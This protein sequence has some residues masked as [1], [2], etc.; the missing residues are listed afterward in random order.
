[1]YLLRRR[2]RLPV[3][4]LMMACNMGWTL[5][6][7][8]DVILS[9]NGDT[10]TRVI[11]L[12][13]LNAAASLQVGM[14]VTGSGIPAGAY[15]T[16]IL[17]GN[18]ILI[19]LPITSNFA[20]GSL[21]FGSVG[22]VKGGT[23]NLTKTGA[24]R[25]V[26]SGNNI[27]NGVVTLTEGT[28]QIGGINYGA[29]TWLNDIIENNTAFVFDA[30]KTTSLDFASNVVSF[31]PFER[32]G[33]IAGGSNAATINLSGENTNTALVVGGNNA[34]TVFTGN[35][36]GEAKSI[37]VKEG[38]GSLTWNSNSTDSMI[39]TIRVEG[40]TLV[41]GGSAGLNDSVSLS[42]SN[43][44]DARLIL[45]ATTAETM[46]YLVGGG[47]GAV[48]SFANGVLG[49]LSGNYL[50]STG[51][52]V[53]L[54]QDQIL[55]LDSS[56]TNA[57]YKYGGS[58]T[59]TGGIT[60]RGANVQE[61][62][63][64][65]TY[66]GATTIQASDLNNS[67]N[68]LRLGAYGTS[69]GVGSLDN[70]GFGSLPSTTRLQ[71]FAGNDGTA[72][73]VA[74]D[75]NGA[76]QTVSTLVSTFTVGDRKVFLRSGTLNINTLGANNSSSFN[77]TF[78]G[79]GTI[80]VLATVGTSGWN[81]TGD[82][83]KT[84]TGSVN[85]QGG[86]L[87][88][89]RS[90]GALG[91]L[92]HVSVNAP[93][94]LDILES[95]AI[96]SL[97]GSGTVSIGSARSLT[98]TSAPSGGTVG[99]AWSGS[100]TGF[101][102]LILATG[103]SLRLTSQ[104]QY[105]GGT[106]L[107]SGSALFLDYG[108][109]SSQLIPSGLTLNGGRIYMS[110]ST[111]QTVSSATLA[112]GATGIYTQF[113]L[114]AVSEALLNIT[115]INRQVGGVL[116]VRGSS[117]STAT[118]AATGGILGG[119][120]TYHTTDGTG[121]PLV[122]WA[123]P[124]GANNA[125]TGFSDFSS[126]FGAG[127]HTSVTSVNAAVT[128]TTPVSGSLGSLTF[129]TAAATTLYIGGVD[130]DKRTEIE[131][132]G[133]LVT[134]TV[135]S[136]NVRITGKVDGV[137]LSGGAGS[138]L[139]YSVK[140]ELIVHQHNT[141]GT[142]T[143]DA[144][145]VDMTSD[146]AGTRLT[147][148]GQGT[149]ILTQLNSY[150]GQ[151]SIFGGVLELASNG[152]NHGSLGN[153]TQP[154]QNY[155]YLVFNRSELAAASYSVANDIIG[156][157]ILRKTNAGTVVL[158][159][160]DSS[161]TGAT[162]VLQG[163][164][165]IANTSNGLGSTDGLTSVSPLSTLELRTVF[166]PETVVLNGGILASSVGASGLTGSLIVTANS[167]L[168]PTSSSDLTLSG[169]VRV[170]PE[171]I[172]SI[173]GTSGKV[174]LTNGSNQIGNM[175]VGA[176]MALQIGDNTAGSV[177]RGVITTGANSDVITNTNNGHLV[178]GSKI[179]GSGEFY[180]VRNTVY[181]TADN[182][183]TGNTTIGGNGTVGL[184]N[185][186]AELRVGTDTYTGNLGTGTITIQSSTNSNSALRYHLLR[187]R[188]VS[189]NIFI[190]PSTNGSTA[191]NATLLRQGIGSI[192]LAGT[193][194]AG[195]HD[196]SP[197][198][199]RAIIQTE[200]GGK[201][202]I[203]G[204]INNGA[205]NA[206]NIINNG[207]IV[208]GGSNNQTLWGILSSGGVNIF[209]D[210]GTITLKG[211]NVFTGNSYI[212]TGTLVVDNDQGLGIQDDADFYLAN[213]AKMQFNYSETVGV[214]VSQKG[215][216]VQ[217][218]NGSVLTIDDNVTIGNFGR[219]TGDG[220][221]RLASNT[222]TSWYGLFGEN[223]L[224][225]DVTIGGA[226]QLTTVRVNSLTMSGQISSLGTGSVVN[227]GVTG[228]TAETRFE[229]I[230]PGETTDRAINLNSGSG[231]IR[232]AGNGKGAL[233][234]DGPVTVTSAGNKTLYLHGQTIGNTI[235]GIIDESTSVLSL[236][237][238]SA[239]GNNDMYGAGRWILTNQDN[240]FSGNVT[241][242]VGVLELAGSLGN[243]TGT[244]SVFGDLTAA[245][246]VD[247]GTNNFD[248][249]RFDVFSGGDNLG[250]GSGLTSTGTIVF[251]DQ[252]VGI[253]TFGSNIKFT[254]SFSSTTNPGGGELV[255]NGN[256]V[257][258]FNGTFTAGDSGNRNW[259]L[260]GTNT[261]TNTINGVISDT[262]TTGS[263]TVGVLKEGSGTWR[264]AGANTYEGTT[265]VAR[266]T[267]ELTGGLAIFDN[268]LI[269]L[270]NAGSDS[271]ADGA[272]L[273]VLQSET[274]GGL[275]G[276]IGSIVDI[277]AGQ[278]L[279]VRSATQT[280]NGIISGLGNLVRTNNDGTFREMTLTNKNTYSGTTTITTNG[281]NFTNNR[282]NLFFL[283][284]GGQAS[285]IGSSSNAA[286]NL[287]LNTGTGGGG[288]RWIGASNQTTDRLFTLGSGSGAGAIWAD[289]Q[290]F[291]DDPAT[292]QFTNT[293]AIEFL[294]S[295]TSQTLT[296]RG[297]NISD[298]IFA[299]LLTNNGS[300]VTS[301]TK[302]DAGMWVLT[303]SNTYSGTTTISG[304]TLAI[305]NGNALGSGSV[306]IAGGAGTGLQ[307]R[308]GITFNNNI[309]N[310][311]TDGGFSVASGDNVLSGTLTLAGT[312]A[313][314]RLGV[315]EGASLNITSA[316]GGA[317]GSA[318]LIKFD[319]GTL[320]LSGNNTYSG[321][322]SISGGTVV[323]NYDT[324]AGGTNSSKLA[325]SQALELG[326][327]NTTGIVTGLGSDGD[328]NGQSYQAGYA[329]GTLILSGGSH[330]EQVG[331]T[332]INNGANAVIR[333]GGTA[334]LQMG[335]ITRATAN[336]VADYGTVD[337]SE[338]GIATTT[339]ANT[340]GSILGNYATISQTDWA[341]VVN[342]TINALTS[343][344]ADSFITNANTD[345]T[346]AS[347][348]APSNGLTN[349]IRFNT[350]NGGATTLT[351]AGILGLQT[352]GILVTKNVT[353]DI[354][355][356]GNSGIL[357]RS[358]TTAN[359]DTVI[360]HFGSG[361]L[362]INVVLA[363]NSG[364]QALTKT[365]TGTV[366][367]NAA[368]TYTGRVN[369]QQGVLQIGNGT[370]TAPVA[371]LG[372]GSNPISMS[373]GATLRLSVA[374][375]NL[376]FT[377]GT[378]NGGG[379]LHLD[380]TNKSI[381]TLASDNG[382]WVGDILIQGGTLRIRANNNAL[383]NIRGI[384][385]IDDGGTLNLHGT[386]QNFPERITINQGGLITVTQNG[387]T[388]SNA[389][390]SG[391]LTLANTNSAGASF[392]VAGSQALT[393]TGMIRSVNG[394]TKLG[395]GILTISAN[396]MQEILAGAAV[397][398]TTPN[399]NPA[400]LGQVIINA[401]EVRLGNARALGA[402]GLGNE[403]IVKSGAS[404]DL[405]GQSLNY[406][407]DPTASR[408]II[409]VAG[410]GFNGLGA[411]KSSNGIGRVSSVVFDD[412]ATLSGGGFTATNSSSRLVI[413]GYDINPNNSSVTA[414]S[415][416]D[417][418]Y[419][420][421][422]AVIDGKNKN[423]TILGSATG[424][425]VNGTGVTLIDP[426]F[427]S[428]LNSITVSEG[429]LRIEKDANRTGATFQGLSSSNVTNGITIA[430]GGPTLADH[431]NSSLG[432]GPN[433]GA[434]LNFYRNWNTVHSVKITMDGDLAKANGGAN[435]IDL[436]TDSSIPNPRT[437]L[438][439]PIILKGDADRNFFHIDASAIQQTLGEQGNQ[440]GTIQSK[441]IISSQITGSGGFTKTGLRELRL[442]NNNT[443]T[444]AV[445]VLRSATAAVPWQDNLVSI[446]GV[447]YQ[448][449]GDGE[450]WAE[451]GMTL[452]GTNGRLSGTSSI[453]LQRRGLITLDNTNRLDA[454]NLV[455]GGN[456]NDRINNAADILF[457][458]G[459]LKIIGGTVDNSES[460]A[461]SG[462][463]KLRVQSG[464]NTLDLMPTD[465]ANTAMTLTI[466]EIVRSPGSILQIN[467]LDSTS[468]FDAEGGAES[469]RVILN[470]IGSLTQVGGSI[471]PGS[472]N[473][474]VV[475]GLL[476]GI[477]PHEYLSDIR[478]LSYNNAGVSDMLNQGRNQQYI[479]SSHFMT[480][481]AATK[482]LRPLDDSEYY[483]PTDG[484]I[485]SLNGSAG[486]NVNL[487]DAYTIVRE[488]VA[489][490][491]LRFGPL[492]DN[493]GKSGSINSTTALTSLVDAHNIQ[494]YVDG[495]LTINSGMI[496]SAYF[497]TGNSNS[498]ATYIMGGTLNFGNR[499]AIINNQNATIRGTDGALITG[500]FEI[501]SSIAG[502]GGLLKTGMA[503]VVL[504]GFNTYSGVT[505]V[506]N[507]T[508]FIRNGR[509]GLGVSGEGNGV[510]IEGNGSLNSGNGIQVGSANAYEN[511]LVKALQGDQQ[512]MRVDNDLTNWF[513]NVIIDNVDAAGQT[514]FTPR[515]R[516]DNNASSI[517]NGNI[518]GG[519]T[520]I[521]D[522]VVSIDSRVVQFDSSTGN[523][524]FILRGQIGDKGD[525]NGKAIPI[526]DPI[527]TLPNLA[528]VRTNENEV[529]RVNFNG[530][531]GETNFMLEQQ[532][533]AAGRLTLIQGNM[534]VTYNP[535]DPNRDGTGFWTD[536]AI[537]KI[538]GASSA[539]SFALNGNTARQGFAFGTT[540]N[541]TSSIFLSKADQVFNMATF[542]SA[543]TGIKT[544]GG[545]NDSGTVY[546]GNSTGTG[547][548][549]VAN[550]A[551]RLYSMAG[552]TTVFDYRIVGNAGTAPNSTGIIKTGRGTVILQ[553][554]TLNAAGN[555]SFEVSGGTLILDHDGMN[556]ARVGGDNAIFGGGVIRALSN[557]AAN[558]T[559]SYAVTNNTNRVLQLKAGTTEV[560]AEGRGSRTLTLNIGNA[561]TNSNRANLTREVGASVNFVEAING[562]GTGI[563]NLN[564]N[565]FSNSILK[566]RLISWATYSNESRTALDFAMS[567]GTAS[568]RVKA[569]N[570]AGGEYLSNVASWADGMDVSEL[571]GSA[572]SG[573]L[574]GS[575]V[576]NTLRFDANAN[577]TVTI[578]SGQTLSLAGDGIA[579]AVLVS[580]NTA[581]TNKTITG[582]SIKAFSASYTGGTT[583]NSNV[584]TSVSSTSNL[585]VGMPISGSGIPSGAYIT[586]ING[587]SITISANAT[588]T[589]AGVAL[590]TQTPDLILHQYGQGTL[591][592]ASTITGSSSLTIAGPATTS[593]EQFG[594]TGVVKLTGNNTYTG[595]T[596]VTGSVLEISDTAALGI[597]PASVTNGHLTLNGGT[598]RWTG[599]VASLGN[600]GI[601]LQG[602]GGVIDVVNETGNLIVGTGISGTQASVTSNQIFR[603]D[604]V[605]MGAGSLTFLGNNASFQ[606][607]MDV[608]EGSLIVMADN[609][610]ANAGS[611]TLLGTSRTLA[612][613][614]ILR[615]G[616]NFQAFL[617]N[618]NNG[619]DWNIEEFFTF[620][621]SNTF[622]YG[623]LLDINANLAVDSLTDQLN[624]GSRRPL[625]L[626]GVLNLQGT[627][628]F[629]VTSNG[630]LRL[631][632]SSGY[633]TG[634]GDIVKDGQGQLHFRAN[635]PDWKGNLVIKQGAV[636]AGNQADVLGTGYVSGST[637]T[638]GD[639][640]RQGFAEL[641]VQNVDGFHAST[642]DI[643][644]NINV[645][646]NPTQTKRLG[647]D[648]MTN[649]TLV[650]Y[651]GNV[652]LNDNL[653]LLIRDTGIS[654]GGEQ[655][656]V[657]FNGSFIDGAITSGNLLVQT[658]DPDTSLNNQTSGRGFGYAVLNGDNSG[659]TGDITISNNA[660]Y[661]QDTTAI[662]RLGNSKALTAANDVIMNYNSILQAGGQTVTIGSLTTQGGVGNFYGD[663]GTMSASTNSSTEIIENAS[664]SK[665]NL[666]I[667]QST[668]V[669][670]EASWDAFFR[671]GTIN[672]QFF[673]PGANVQQVSASLSLT[674]AGS[675]WATLTLDNDYTGT[676]TVKAGVLQV[677]RNGV[678]DTGTIAYQNS[679][680]T[681]MTSVLS[682]GTIAGSG[683]VQGRLSV[684]SGGTLKTGDS[685]GAAIGTLTVTGDALFASGSNALLQLHSASY[686]N[687]GAL[688][689]TDPNYQYWRD[690]VTTDSFSTA[691]GDLV[692]NAQH[693]LLVATGTIAFGTGAKITL[694]N[695]GYTPKA[696]DVFQL[697]QGAGYV[698]NLNVG[699]SLRTGGETTIPNLDLIL[700]A[701]GGNLLWDV[702]LFNSHGIVMVV[703]T[704]TTLDTSAQLPPVITEQPSSNQSQT[705]KLDPGTLV[706]VSALAT[707]DPAA[708]ALRYQWLHNGIPES[709]A[710]SR[711][712]TYT[713]PANFN[714][715][716][717]YTVAVTNNYGTVLSSG[718]V[719]VLVEDLP[720]ITVDP[721]SVT[722]DPAS[723]HT[724]SIAVG[725]QDPFEY[726]WLKDGD[727]IEGATNATLSLT[728]IVEADQGYYSVIVTNVAGSATSAEAFLNVRDP[729]TNVA[730]AMSPE[731]S[732][733][734]QNIQFTSTH[735]G[736]GPFTYQWTKNGT[737]IPSA[738][739]SSYTI[740]SATAGAAGDYRL[741]V[742]TSV[743]SLPSSPLTL[744]LKDPVPVIAAAPVSQT[745]LSGTPLDLKVEATGR[746]VLRYSWKKNGAVL[747]TSLTADISTSSA[748]LED[749]GTYTVE[750]SN[751]A[752]KIDTT[753]TPVEIVVVDSANRYLPVGLGGTAVFTARVG[754]G[755][756]TPLSYEWLRVRTREIIVDGGE[757]GPE[758]DE[759]VIEEFYEELPTNDSRYVG[760]NSAV[761]KLN[762]VTEDEDGLYRCKITGPDQTAVYGS[763]LD[764]SIYTEAPEFAGT[765]TFDD[766][767]I[768]RAY[769][770]E[771]PVNREERFKSPDKITA[772]GLPPGLK[773]DPISGIISGIPTATKAGGYTVKVTLANKKG[774]VTVAGV[775][776]VLDLNDTIPGAWVGLVDR[777]PELGGDLGGRVDLIVTTKATYSGKLTLG[778]FSYSFKGPL[779]V[780][781]DSPSGTVY[782]KRSGKP[783][784]DPLRLDFVLDPVNNTI[785][786]GQI[787]D[788]VSTVDFTGWRQVFSKT[789]PANS[790]TGYYTT[791][792]AL[793]DD[794][795]LINTAGNEEVPQGAG[796]ATFAVATDG[797]LKIAGRMPDGEA[798]TN[799]TFV[800]PNG[801]LAMFQPMYK[802]IKPGGSIL[803]VFNIDDKGDTD[804]L[805]S[806][807]S[808]SGEISWIR[809]ASIKST[810]RLFKAGFGI[811]G[812][813]VTEPLGVVAIGGRYDAPASGK[814]VLGMNE[815]AV[816]VNNA[817]IDFYNGG[818]LNYTYVV[819]TQTLTSMNPD[820]DLAV[821]K[822]SKVTVLKETPNATKTSVKAV[823]KTG[824]L[825]GAFTTTDFNPLFPQKPDVIKR[826][827]KFQGV[828]IREET[829]G[830]TQL[831]GV[832][833][834]LLPQL[835][836]AAGS[837]KPATTDKTSPIYSGRFVF[838]EL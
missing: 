111:A 679:V 293:G 212:R 274:I 98:L 447:D 506:S 431:T 451:W 262:L 287:I 238:N 6:S 667:A 292:L 252:E 597:N 227:L 810:D 198:T 720:A 769:S 712:A 605:K 693:D 754:A 675:G 109:I 694:E 469:V 677:G 127:V 836:R 436:G 535:N 493:D 829:D 768:G 530:G 210:G 207:T 483:S 81:I 542:N 583:N 192:T 456:N 286:S 69:A 527:S 8:G 507:G 614:T 91:D 333:N 233:I 256:K 340:T 719:T 86:K 752:G 624:L 73:N 162:Q 240:N 188:V 575:K 784:P 135:G 94:E 815:P 289:G 791:A 377:S 347:V 747:A 658:D 4:I 343:Y 5:Q 371:R 464:T 215:S 128:A 357:R 125:I 196:L 372:A 600:R 275:T 259:I 683:I 742:T 657:N 328:V 269:S 213:G 28:L 288:L 107:N 114:P 577:S 17:S 151:T 544:I 383:G 349:T 750:V 477:M 384:T 516:T 608:R 180:Q 523:N 148:V 410:A 801:E 362:N 519:S 655:S 271:V 393:L 299:P 160:A 812:S 363:N 672:S 716:G 818:D 32:I 280:Y 46:N 674:K 158:R 156:S 300:G 564:F 826:G 307:F 659:W 697:F 88:L 811:A 437:Y 216:V 645:V 730:I 785:T 422:E 389:T 297:S 557:S 48:T 653:I 150:T 549:T 462:G 663:A 7:R 650:A 351:L 439:G 460:L 411:L 517:I 30:T 734:G 303:N 737:N 599:G 138:A 449:F 60:K 825:S 49:A 526:A 490:N 482:V 465:G 118:A 612:D 197:T 702:S 478:Q 805:N 354:T 89:N 452:S 353:D 350:N 559:V 189:N 65:N 309:T 479:A 302:A 360:H 738:N 783:T 425:D 809:P 673:A 229:Y 601:D 224:S 795:P 190:N 604:L 245:R 455:A 381:F 450:A 623:S 146:P 20:S 382:N 285:G 566:N 334:V 573:T 481:D 807:N 587:N 552:G 255:N 243:G 453:N 695:D 480:Y 424:N 727:P 595:A 104:Q 670:Y 802:A 589:N 685:A 498:L 67:N 744:V 93:G 780:D 548:L 820:I 591:T 778:T 515:I 413:A 529:L 55:T 671:D 722:V 536:T 551:L 513:S 756:K 684:L 364:V 419:Q 172:L 444:G 824:L 561:N 454:T 326:F 627:A 314:L 92:V 458:H 130:G 492:S 155:G 291:G 202:T 137:A 567:D 518:Y 52:E 22:E 765:L 606:G 457:N 318:R 484:L 699:P 732:F 352:G 664:A 793:P 565:N 508:L 803:G 161:Y 26:L 497:S 53:S 766:A 230:G 416:L 2:L 34:S 177:G 124:N 467:D 787:T 524:V 203:S 327:Y 341:T 717:T 99:N 628:T 522:D 174:I 619:G 200:G 64:D 236:N 446:N 308:G 68:I 21:T 246:V 90:G 361:L 714:T 179:T 100:I 373:D 23:G 139:G 50:N 525:A 700:F 538:P 814:V 85:V 813:P 399:A 615:T 143:I 711:Q 408:E 806:N 570:R 830:G 401:G 505:T 365:G 234:L 713:F 165:A 336:A 745:L 232:I 75:L 374:N 241:V 219:F 369:I 721:S 736:D 499:E 430:Y 491:T 488:N 762:K 290:N 311:V 509:Q 749:G 660:V 543:G 531:S 753:Q 29:R 15:I 58:I 763:G 395:N 237:V 429:T 281:T 27:L 629:D 396:Q 489:V 387:T 705:E 214:L 407:D 534:I 105:L 61:L 733:I 346:S 435:Y 789:A 97:V 400:L 322:T 263:N 140:D 129:N 582:G 63:G 397:G 797:K 741:V 698:G 329:G 264:L 592:V 638:L 406:G 500:N 837:G 175:N 106:T 185:Q 183:Y 546:Y 487:M 420:R 110:G 771:V 338:A 36:R 442:I 235:N 103:A 774:K 607:L 819:G 331:S 102:S 580:S 786:S 193:I 321:I 426:K 796:Y 643:N 87:S 412:D 101:G 82:S 639:A 706:T 473:K 164:L 112:N 703:E 560:T 283:A 205:T 348:T 724:F 773:M 418:N 409:H 43:A 31:T 827:V 176:N 77:G 459:W 266:G 159:G 184:L 520:T 313:N 376:E 385:T 755:K 539:S 613:G 760:I 728:G 71:L 392:D 504:D 788:G 620:E 181:L 95:D 568:N 648:G 440:T 616:T 296:L 390:L 117:L 781:E 743:N 502:R 651:N 772:S 423:L 494:L 775:L 588:A 541:G 167:Q 740:S 495:T 751:T 342:S 194:T 649:T 228:G 33:S 166:S 569:F 134:P 704:T 596:Y 133:I 359:L 764:L 25:T 691:L 368:N 715:K 476:G 562:T 72:K 474:S 147:K 268:G 244:N 461:T 581:A 19:N 799:S 817:R 76:T 11:S 182:D 119:Y 593:P 358:S 746:P 220:E 45:N 496:S 18:Q 652:T 370:L 731:D 40:G 692:T 632:N 578:T 428:A 790:Y 662:L 78:E 209:S 222:G 386:T 831:V 254:Q 590:T 833:Y 511:I 248:G 195:S 206:L 470:S 335:A 554:S 625:N 316:I 689:A 123:V 153:G 510:V 414:G 132:G 79:L 378:I 168:S 3:T 415:L 356:T 466:G 572:F 375:S 57:V 816:P 800:G 44:A 443:F 208:Y 761:L 468:R 556:V 405:R 463:A 558:T 571:S 12:N 644:H 668:P 821:L 59:G 563:I 626:N 647:I 273:R 553:N 512:I 688:A 676:T 656:Y 759:T 163:K 471:V 555:S 272:I 257:L 199:Q 748:A 432:V 610:N 472:T 585:T 332:R 574:N 545:I 13:G 218:N 278:S 277:A 284:D 767:L 576:L 14:T 532:Y 239:A 282:I 718:S 317:L 74:F 312:N 598:L 501:R 301:L 294:A 298:N 631:N 306:T 120:A 344:T 433:V 367:L 379:L 770:F 448:T 739:Q 665:A 792:I 320:T 723:S 808:V 276:S 540:S 635:T 445:N 80:N 84:Q 528:G 725:G 56:V 265:T 521:S 170:Y 122:T 618:G 602:G 54:S 486:Q 126:L 70:A 258:V 116:Q 96:G 51:G 547:T 191:R 609:G 707:G 380:T 223:E 231:S 823:A 729:I 131:S 417:G 398:A 594:T 295:N 315:A 686:N 687:P 636:Y 225:S 35:I 586:A 249:R 152:A 9:S 832:G 681:T 669:T 680:L 142:L 710:E 355:I 108:D 637:I 622:T 630:I 782:I 690:A 709:S 678:G 47:R 776:N 319:R 640:E 270:S 253:A 42:I 533:N 634:S 579:G 41:I 323:L 654:A 83:N 838:E 388:R 1:M 828:I 834:F 758:D 337:F 115:T 324:N 144:S 330:A 345:I 24:G 149:L 777:D 584:I 325:N 394:F 62:Y 260:D 304:G 305:T 267:L 682:G 211:E 757:E 39:G 404:L 402:T 427:V 798:I 204:Q 178:F 66:S 186:N 221:L 804:S 391:I 113:D 603:G 779:N 735:D 366:V 438:S 708:G 154:V 136:N 279:T 514:I 10:D 38:S 37:F 310:T 646:Y 434:R 247:L 251:N 822:G 621:G 250:A 173:T 696:G 421:V 617:G 794:S 145:I 187:N 261:G 503:Q 339:T 835:P 633:L 611:T 403:T 666:T 726:Q 16:Q 701:L 169:T 171:A 475:I 641:L 201:L 661:N 226:N 441:L 242:N 550:S 642:Y 157:G 141:R 217:L 537:S 121:K 485:D